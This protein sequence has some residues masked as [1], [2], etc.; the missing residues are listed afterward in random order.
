[1]HRIKRQATLLL[2]PCTGRREGRVHDGKV[3]VMCSNL[4]RYSDGLAFACWNGE[5]IRMAFIIDAFDGE[6]IAWTA[7]SQTG[8][9]GSDVR[10]MER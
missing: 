1:M 4:C 3:M 10:D 9:S 7:V 5:I 6:I 2:E 8:I